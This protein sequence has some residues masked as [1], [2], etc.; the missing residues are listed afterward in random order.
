[1]RSKFDIVYEEAFANLI[2]EGV[3]ENI[4]NWLKE[5]VAKLMKSSAKTL[6]DFYYNN[7]VLK[8]IRNRFGLTDEV[9]E[10]ITDECVEKKERRHIQHSH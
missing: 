7:A 6:R 4:L 1:M 8:K 10:K 3:L 5:K 2:A 9:I